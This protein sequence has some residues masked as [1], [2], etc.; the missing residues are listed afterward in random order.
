MKIEAENLGPSQLFGF[1][2]IQGSGFEG[3]HCSKILGIL[4]CISD[5][6]LHYLFTILPL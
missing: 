3:F 6:I 5:H 1:K 2:G 4:T